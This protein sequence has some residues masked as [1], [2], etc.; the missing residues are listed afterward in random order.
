MDLAA[1][2]THSWWALKDNA[3]NPQKIDATTLVT[4][5]NAGIQDL[6]PVL[7]KVKSAT[8]TFTAGVATL[9]TDFLEPIAAYDGDTL[10]IQIDDI[11]DKVED[12]A[13][14]SQYFIPNSTQIYLYGTTPS[15]TVTL[16]YLA[17]PAALSQTTDVPSDVPTRFHHFIAEIWVP[18]MVALRN[19][20]LADY[21]AF[22]QLWQQVRGEVGYA[23]K[24][25]RAAQ[26]LH[27]IEVAW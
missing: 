15:G 21:G 12:D 11:K 19:N 16:W 26:V 9:P 14:T 10:L 4:V 23:C 18:A 1:L 6:G 17:S 2:K 20:Q 3:S 22:I 13:T 5:I 7:N 24:H 25:D 8:P 27:G